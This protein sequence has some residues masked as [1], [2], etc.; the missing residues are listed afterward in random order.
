MTQTDNGWGLT[1]TVADPVQVGALE[2]AIG[3]YL[4]SQ[5]D[6]M[7]RVTQLLDDS[8]SLP[9]ALCLRGYLLRLA[10]NPKFHV[11]LQGV[12]TQLRQM[13]DGRL[14]NPRERLHAEALIL[15]C[16][17]RGDLAVLRLEALL[18]AYPLDILALRIAHYLHFYSGIPARMRDSTARVLAAWPTDHYHF[19]YLLG[20]HA[21]GLE[22]SGDYEAALAFGQRAVVR[23]PADIWA[24]HAVAHVYQMQQKFQQGLDWLESLNAH[25]RSANNFRHH[26]TWHAALYFLGLDVPQRALQIYDAQLA[27]SAADDFYLDMCNNAALLWRLTFVG[28]EVGTR[29]EALAE[30]CVQH[31]EDRE[32]VFAALH[33]LIPLAVTGSG[34]AQRLVETLRQWGSQSGEQAAVSGRVGVSLAEAIVHAGADR[35]RGAMHLRNAQNDLFRIGGSHA[36]RDLFHLL[37]EHLGAH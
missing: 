1:Y 29:W 17:D 24:T 10:A 8:P 36:Q 32:L 15:W 31:S 3:A 5:T 6:A 34:H 16:E 37:G 21:F 9:M 19:G 12:L 26:L 30:I 7:A 11:P 28:V 14:C 20:M 13:L 25:W 33:Y 4:G 2:A 23:N 22:E 35:Q 18:Q 27:D